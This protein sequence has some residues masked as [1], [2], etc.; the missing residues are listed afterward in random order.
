MTHLQLLGI[1]LFVSLAELQEFILQYGSDVYI[2]P[3]WYDNDEVLEN[4][5]E[6]EQILKPIKCI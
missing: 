6:L 1:S 3:E 5:D 4:L 2:I